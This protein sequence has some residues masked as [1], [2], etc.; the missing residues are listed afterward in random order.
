MVLVVTSYP[1]IRDA[2][3]GL[4]KLTKAKIRSTDLIDDMKEELRMNI[5][6]LKRADFD[7]L[8][9]EQLATLAD[10][11]RMEYM[12]A[13]KHEVKIIRNAICGRKVTW[14]LIDGIDANKTVGRDLRGVFKSI[15]RMQNALRNVDIVPVDRPSVRLK[16]L[17]EYHRVA[18][19]LLSR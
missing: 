1:L 8:N 13:Y 18:L 12:V 19:R 17:L 2:L 15:I 9:N 16:N 5:N 14:V 11:L 4:G 10:R 6:L 7:G 3:A